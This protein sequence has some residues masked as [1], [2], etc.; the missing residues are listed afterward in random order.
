MLKLRSPISTISANCSCVSC[1][2]VRN[3]LILLPNNSFIL[4]LLILPNRPISCKV[5]IGMNFGPYK[6]EDYIV[7]HLSHS[8]NTKLN[9]LLR[10][11]IEYCKGLENYVGQ[12]LH[13]V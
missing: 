8:K 1:F 3:S 12:E 7:I 5:L 10:K 6:I 13:T 11:N 2:C 4:P 9:Q